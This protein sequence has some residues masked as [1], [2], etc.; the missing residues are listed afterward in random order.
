MCRVPKP[1]AVRHMVEFKG[2][3]RYFESLVSSGARDMTVLALDF[4]GVL[5]DS[6]DETAVSAWRAGSLLWG[7]MVGQRPPAALLEAY[8]QTR[9]AVETGYQAILA[10][11]LLLDG[12]PTERVLEGF[13]RTCR[14]DPLDK[15]LGSGGAR[16]LVWGDARPLAGRCAGGVAADEPLLSRGRGMAQVPSRIGR[17]LYRHDQGAAFRGAPAC[18][19]RA[20]SSTPSASTAWRRANLRS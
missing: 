18:G 13:C 10:M 5:C 6:V 17:C 2:R 4:D 12:E 16:G 15:R 8:R 19:Q 7:D 9:P 3:G 14:G 11:R 1:F 20:L